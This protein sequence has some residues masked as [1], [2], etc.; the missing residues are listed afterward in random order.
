MT[1]AGLMQKVTIVLAALF[2]A[3]TISACEEQG[4][5][6]QTSEAIEESAESAA[7]GAAEMVEEGAEAI[8]D[9]VEKV[10]ESTD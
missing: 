6:E 9:G 1:I 3:F 2:L 8:E 4:A 10:Q 5:V 7:E